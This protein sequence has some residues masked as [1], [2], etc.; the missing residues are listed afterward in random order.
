MSHLA[1]ANITVG[2]TVLGRPK[3]WDFLSSSAWVTL[4]IIHT[5]PTFVVSLRGV[6][7]EGIVAEGV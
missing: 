5:L 3:Q 2:L 6:Y 1:G 4:Q 7:C